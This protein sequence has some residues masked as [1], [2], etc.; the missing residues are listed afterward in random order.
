MIILALDYG[1][2]GNCSTLALVKKDTSMDWLCLP[3]FDSPSVFSKILDSDNGGSFKIIPV[4]EYEIKQE[5]IENTNVIKTTFSNS[6]SEFEVI[7]YFPYYKKGDETFRDSEVQRII[8]RKR[9]NPIIKVLIKPKME[10]NKYIPN[11]YIEDGKIIFSHKSISL[12]V[13]SN[14][15]LKKLSN[16]DKIE[17]PEKSYILISYNKLK[18]PIDVDYIMQEMDNT[19]DYWRN[20]SKKIFGKKDYKPLKV[21]SALVL[22]LL[23]YEDTGA[24]IAAGTTSIPEIKGS[25]RNWD[26]RYSW[27][28]DYSFS[29]EA[30]MKIGLIDQAYNFIRWLNLLYSKYGINV[31]TLFNVEGE[32][33]IGELKLMHMQG[34][35]NS[36]P[37]RIGNAAYKQRQTDIIGELLNSLYLFYLKKN[38]N[39]RVNEI[40][41]DLISNFVETAIKDWKKK[42]H[43]IWEFRGSNKNYT[44]SKVM[45]WVALDRGIKIAKKLGHDEVIERWSKDRRNIKVNIMRYGWNK[46]AQ[47][48]TQHYGS[49]TLDASLLLMPSFGIIR[50]KDKRMLSTINA[51]KRELSK[52]PFVMRYKDEDG[53]GIPKSAFITCSFWLINALYKIGNKE[54]AMDMFNKA[55]AFQNHMGLF[56]EDIDIDTGELLGNFPQSYSHVALI[57]TITI[58]SGKK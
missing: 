58:L 37:V 47:A 11:K 9:G 38:K 39:L 22:Q 42:D 19:I 12:Y 18:N 5:Y 56:S 32:D 1:V 48:F 55:V 35:E 31:Q 51:I 15:N 52:G 6:T 13:Y 26:Y 43:S 20:W 41:W 21:R 36:K 7:D 53:F 23:T 14:L 25:V 28:R 50:W 40:S 57:N 3:K 46:K 16:E 33:Y 30:L 29:V 27:I 8:I 45:C 17:L 2:I 54:E 44:F 10:Y 24:M 4:D 49:T 34:Y